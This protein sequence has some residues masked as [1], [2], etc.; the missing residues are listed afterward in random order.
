MGPTT[1]TVLPRLRASILFAGLLAIGF[2]AI[3]QSTYFIEYS[4]NI[5]RLGAQDTYFYVDFDEPFG[6]NCLYG[7]AFITPE[8]KGLYSQ[9]LAAKLAGKRISRFDYSQPDGVGTKC[10]AELV[11]I[12]N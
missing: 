10:I 6:Q 2:Q 7:A 1:S 11:E 12:I 4:K 8:K 9:L 3:A 5:K